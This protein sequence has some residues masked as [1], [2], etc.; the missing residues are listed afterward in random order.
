MSWRTFIR[1]WWTR[2]W[3]RHGIAVQPVHLHRG[4]IGEAAAKSYLKEQGLSFLTAN[5]RSKRG[6]ID[7][8]FR[9]QRCVVF[10]EVKTRSSEQWT[11]P[12][13]A[14]NQPKQKRISRAALDYLQEIG[15][16][17][18]AIRFDI[19]EVLIRGQ[20]VGTIRH[21]PNAFQLAKPYRYG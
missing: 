11:R 7:L 5:Y 15:H 10:V 20:T 8:I 14:V 16:P 2:L 13:A 1:D 21:L 6:E 4:R 17:R 19:V 3:A 9:E 18:I 12:A